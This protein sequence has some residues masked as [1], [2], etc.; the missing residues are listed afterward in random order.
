MPNINYAYTNNVPQATQ[1]R[2][3]T[4]QPINYNFQDINQ[5]IAVNH[6]SFNTVDIFGNHTIVDFFAQNA[7]PTTGANEIAM[8]SKPT[9]DTNGQQLFYR[10]PNNGQ[11]AQLTSASAS[12][13]TGDGTGSTTTAMGAL[14]NP[15]TVTGTSSWAGSEYSYLGGGGSTIGYQYL[16]GGVLMVYGEY[17]FTYN[18]ATTPLLFP[19]RPI[20]QI[21]A[22]TSQ[23]FNLQVTQNYYNINYSG[24]GVNSSLLTS[25]IVTNLSQFTVNFVPQ[26]T[27]AT[28][29]FIAIGI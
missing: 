1:Q 19:F 26:T 25:G 9:S 17:S 11:I 7:D 24:L 15:Q 23:I 16:T 27:N 21:P 20:T 3:S 8:Y 2:N 28:F 22:F 18:G 14:Y 5:F 29:S 13:S 12:G 6:E 10:Y 4:Q